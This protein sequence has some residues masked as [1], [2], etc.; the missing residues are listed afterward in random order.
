LWFFKTWGNIY[1]QKFFQKVLTISFS[2]LGCNHH[3]GKAIADVENFITNRL[4]G[5]NYGKN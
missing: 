4:G 1:F 2:V 5:F 3:N